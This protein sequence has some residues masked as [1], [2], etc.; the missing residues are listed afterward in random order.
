MVSHS[1]THFTRVVERAV[2]L[3]FCLAEEDCSRGVT[4]L[5]AQLHLSKATVFRLLQT[6]VAKGLVERN[7]DNATYGL[8]PR[9]VL[10]GL[11]FIPQ[12]LMAV[13]RPHLERLRDL[14][15]ETATLSIRVGD[16]RVFLDVV[17]S[18][19]EVK[20]VPN[21][22]R[23]VSLI[24]GASGKVL[25]AFADSELRNRLI[26]EAFDGRLKGSIDRYKAELAL[27]RRKGCASSIQERTP[28]ASS[29]AAAVRDQFGRVVATVSL[30]AP[31]NR[32]SR[33]TMKRLMPFLLDTA[34]ILSRDLG[35]LL[36]IESLAKRRVLPGENALLS[37][38]SSISE[39]AT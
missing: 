22:G 34:S 11:Q 28:G 3:L 9:L 8:T 6:L 12:M 7:A 33:S 15:G 38:G 26:R 29:I 24:H 16:Q 20:M 35:A 19:L 1:E 32:L 25:L 2:D 13:A 37:T 17:P 31:T 36:N 27:I 5:A 4:Q 14:S 30:S 18:L 10:L 39:A 23:P 21:R